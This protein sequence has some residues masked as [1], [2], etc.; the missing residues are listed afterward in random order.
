[1]AILAEKWRE[2]D[3]LLTY[4]LIHVSWFCLMYDKADTLN[5]YA[6]VRWNEMNVVL[7]HLCAHIGSTGT[8]DSEMNET[9]LP[10]RHRIQNSCPG[11]W[12][13]TLYL[14]MTDVPHNIETLRVSGEETFL[15]L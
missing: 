1:M 5:I 15:F 4:L 12:G 2:K 10:S 13:R 14:L 8:E 3:I 11:V 9:T 7:G 6:F